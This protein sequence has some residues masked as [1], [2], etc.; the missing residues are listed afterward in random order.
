MMHPGRNGWSDK[1]AQAVTP[2]SPHSGTPLKQGVNE[3]RRSHTLKCVAFGFLLAFAARFES[4]AEEPSKHLPGTE[5][6]KTFWLIP[7]THWEGAVCKTRED[8]LEMGLPHVRTAIRPH[9]TH[10][11]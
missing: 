7:H 11:N 9:K 8:Y 1:T 10:P 4:S 3:K 5:S 2:P 6:K